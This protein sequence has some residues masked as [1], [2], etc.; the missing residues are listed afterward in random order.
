MY[1]DTSIMGNQKTRLQLDRSWDPVAGMW[2][3]P[4]KNSMDCLKETVCQ[5]GMEGLY[6]GLSAS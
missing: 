2:S 4:Y 5:E 6:E 3:R 1:S